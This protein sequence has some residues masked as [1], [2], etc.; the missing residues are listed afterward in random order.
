LAARAGDDRTLAV[1]D[2]PPGTDLVLRYDVKNA[3]LTSHGL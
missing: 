1:T 3:P 2:P